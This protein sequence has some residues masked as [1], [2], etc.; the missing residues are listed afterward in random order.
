MEIEFRTCPRL[1]AQIPTTTTNT[2]L[3]S[4]RWGLSRRSR[5]S[6]SKPMDRQQQYGALEAR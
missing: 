3:G 1:A 4:N 2:K 5:P 6:V